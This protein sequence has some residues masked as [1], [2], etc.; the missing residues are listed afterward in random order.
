MLIKDNLQKMI[1][2]LSPWWQRINLGDGI[3]T[4]GSCDSQQVWSFVKN[5]F[6]KKL[7]G[8]HVL[9]VGCNA[10]FFSFKASELGARYV[11]GIDFD[12]HIQQ[13]NFIKEIKKAKNVK[14]L[15]SS[16]YDFPLQK[17][18]NLT[19][20]LGLLYHLKYPFLALKKISELTTEMVILETEVLSDARD[21]E[22]MKFIEHT[23]RDD[24][25]TWWI[26]G[27]ECIKGMLRSVGFP[28]VKS[29]LYPDEHTVFGRHYY[30]GLTQEG[31]KR[32]KRAVIIGLKKLDIERIGILV[33]ETPDLEKEID[34]NRIDCKD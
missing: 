23:Y 20:C 17:K 11:T 2:R 6:P 13:A 16:I 3:Y 31:F 9:D 25:T 29:Y 32:G 28:H 5:Y 24:S 15:S 8:M 10:G 7:E 4:P 26:F 19:L 34:L 1:E 14:F 18:F 30:E 27:Q 21:A 12:Y 33:S 22:K